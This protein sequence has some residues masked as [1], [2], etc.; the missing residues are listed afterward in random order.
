MSAL[1]VKIKE[2]IS[3]PTNASSRIFF[4]SISMTLQLVSKI[5]QVKIRYYTDQEG[6]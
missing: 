4:T 1:P 3:F 6:K 2:A 5:P